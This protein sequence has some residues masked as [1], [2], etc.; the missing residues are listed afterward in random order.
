MKHPEK[1]A[2]VHIITAPATYMILDMLRVKRMEMA[3]LRFYSANYQTGTSPAQEPQPQPFPSSVVLSE[4]AV[5]ARFSPTEMPK[6][7]ITL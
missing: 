3:Q 4:A 2:K 6:E 7:G 5:S 1:N